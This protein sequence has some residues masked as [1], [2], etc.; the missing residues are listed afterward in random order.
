MKKPVDYLILA[1]LD[2]ELTALKTALGI[3]SDTAAFFYPDNTPYWRVTIERR[4]GLEP[5]TVHVAKL[6]YQG[7]LN[8][9]VAAAR[10]L[11]ETR[12]ACVVSFGIAG[13]FLEKITP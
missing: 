5:V 2:D 1:P 11:E 10:I 13:G 3:S 7:V 12:A 6:K 9:A 4:N 8:A